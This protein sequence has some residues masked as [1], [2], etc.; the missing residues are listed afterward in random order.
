MMDIIQGIKAGYDM[1]LIKWD[2]V[3]F[4]EINFFLQKCLCN[5]EILSSMGLKFVGK[6]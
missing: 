3:K 6:K 2:V 5:M 4:D 1:Y